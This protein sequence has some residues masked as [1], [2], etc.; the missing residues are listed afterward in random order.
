MTGTRKSISPA[1]K[2]TAKL[3]ATKRAAIA[4]KNGKKGGRPRSTLPAEVLDR[5]GPPPAAAL[6]QAAWASQL[7]GELVLLQGKGEIDRDLA[8]ALRATATAI[9]RAVPPT[10]YAEIDRKL[11]AEALAIAADGLGPATQPLEPVRAAG[12]SVRRDP[13]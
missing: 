1:A 12:P 11:S 5:L 3:A 4:R 13:R 6:A 8:A 2:S 10:T 9:H 7:L